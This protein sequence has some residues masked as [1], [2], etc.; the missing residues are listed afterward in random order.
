MATTI[1]S[2]QIGVPLARGMARRLIGALSIVT[3]GLSFAGLPATAQEPAPSPAGEASRLEYG[4]KEG[5]AYDYHVKVEATVENQVHTV[6][7]ISSYTASRPKSRIAL[8]PQEETGS[9]FA[10]S[11]DGNLVTCAHVV[12]GAAKVVVQIADKKY[13]ATV[14]A[15]N[16]RLDLAL[17]KIEAAGMTPLAIAESN[18][19]ELGQ[20]VRTVGYP[21]TDVLGD[22]AKITRGTVAGIVL[23]EG[24]KLIQVDAS[25][26]Q[27]NSGGPAVDERGQVVGVASEKLYG[28]RISNVGFCVPSDELRTWLKERGITPLSGNGDA[29]LTG[30]AL[31]KKVIPGVALVRVTFGPDGPSVGREFVLRGSGFVTTETRH[32][33]PGVLDFGLGADDRMRHDQSA[34][35][36]DTFGQ[37]SESI[38]GLN[39]PFLLGP[40]SALTI[41]PLSPEGRSAWKIERPIQLVIQ[42]ERSRDDDPLSRLLDDR[43]RGRFRPPLGRPRTRTEFAIIPATETLEYEI[44]S[45]DDQKVTIRKKQKLMARVEKESPEGVDLTGEGELTFNRQRG[46]IDRME[47]KAEYSITGENVT[48]RF[49]YTVSVE[50][51]NID[52]ATARE[53]RKTAEQ[54]Q[55]PEPDPRIKRDLDVLASAAADPAD[56]LRA[57]ESLASSKRDP[58]SRD[59]VVAA[60]TSLISTGEPPSRVLA[61]KALTHWDWATKIGDV[62][63][64]LSEEDATVRRAAIE[65][66]GEMQ[67]AQAAPALIKHI[68]R[69][70]D[71]DLVVAALKLIGPS[72]EADV[73]RLLKHQDPQVRGDGCRILAQIGGDDSI[74]PLRALANG[75]DPAA[76]AAKDALAHMGVSLKPRAP[77]RKKPA[78]AVEEEENPFDPAPK[79]RKP[80]PVE[81][82][83]NPFEPAP[84]AKAPAP[85]KSTQPKT[86]AKSSTSNSTD[87]SPDAS[88]A[89]S[90]AADP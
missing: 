38:D 51:A 44:Q 13:D 59:A 78:A 9:A 77:K 72:V 90:K 52:R 70:D 14:V 65:Y 60:L 2:W 35:E 40:L 82:E 45:T 57:L 23:I 81:E 87:K 88:R 50:P 11:D 41:E 5:E 27:G 21:L 1:L 22:S 19:V 25:I 55:K 63:P 46:V 15:T 74:A 71:R 29:A 67:D 42:Q 68:A 43:L 37:V 12:A 24:R 36:V 7:G 54:P 49:P 34:F 89:D 56:R 18:Q 39:L 30:P 31:A 20:E 28:A 33:D 66:L 8:P 3:W 6:R 16:A 86:A 85:K 58:E 53:A 73:L 32:A 83:E 61:L 26:N 75:D 47:L 17:I 84:K 79:K 10:V 62:T 76:A 48:I 69:S 4:W 64:L 80:A